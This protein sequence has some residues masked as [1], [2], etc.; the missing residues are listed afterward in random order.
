MAQKTEPA[1]KEDNFVYVGID[2][3]VSVRRD[4][5]EASKALVHVL[6]GAH[7]L[8]ETRIIKQKLTEELRV[9]L[10]ELGELVLHV[11][12]LLPKMPELPKEEK[13]KPVKPQPKPIPQPRP[14]STAPHIDKFERELED[15]ER[16]LKEL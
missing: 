8:R 6:K 2:D 4:V 7:N 1:K 9:R 3:P 15:I 5:L 12:Q 13:A 14:A 11:Q 16:R 10:S